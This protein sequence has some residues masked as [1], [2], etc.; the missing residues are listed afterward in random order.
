MSPTDTP[1]AT[2]DRDAEDAKAREQ[3][4]LM[5]LKIVVIVLGAI[6]VAMALVVFSTLIVR[7]VK[8][9][10][11]DPALAAPSQAATLPAA[12]AAAPATTPAAAPAARSGT[13]PADVVVPPGARVVSSALG[14]GRFALTL[15][16]DGHLTIILFDATTLKELGRTTLAPPGPARP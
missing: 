14:E 3:A 4:R 15:E 1:Q 9:R 10:G 16:Q 6:L 7:A 12:P 13:A 5:A 8:G 2:R 11:A